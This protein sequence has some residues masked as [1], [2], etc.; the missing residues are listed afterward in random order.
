MVPFD[1]GNGDISC[2]EFIIGINLFY[3]L[4]Q[5]QRIPEISLS[6]VLC[7][8]GK[9]VTDLILILLVFTPFF[10]PE[11]T[12]ARWMWLAVIPWLYLSGSLVFSYLTYLDPLN[13][14]ELPWVRKLE[15]IPTFSLLMIFWAYLSWVQIQMRR[16][17]TRTTP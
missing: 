1:P 7:N 17:R 12:E 9:K 16:I 10:T 4:Q 14:G 6:E 2:D 13:F 8:L 11:E 3:L 5:V 15:W